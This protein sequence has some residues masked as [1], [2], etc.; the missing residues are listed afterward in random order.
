MWADVR[1]YS[2]HVQETGSPPGR[3]YHLQRRS[4]H[5]RY[6]VGAGKRRLTVKQGG[7]GGQFLFWIKLYYWEFQKRNVHRV[8]T[9][10]LDWL[11]IIVTFRSHFKKFKSWL[12]FLDSVWCFFRQYKKVLI[13]SKGWNQQ[14]WY[15][16]YII[17]SKPNSNFLR[18]IKS[19][20][21]G[22][23]KR[24]PGNNPCPAVSRGERMSISWAAWPMSGRHG[25]EEELE[26]EPEVWVW[27]WTFLHYV[28]TPLPRKGWYQH[29]VKGKL[30]P[31][32]SEEPR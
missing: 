25:R 3:T 11:I 32:L 12:H 26:V 17:L 7:V 6:S 30:G 16:N 28:L 18:S 14:N 31:E 9:V 15:V 23:W 20:N 29:F 8:S 19:Q 27:N 22:S 10:G 5:P 13:L 24:S 21:V 2:A 1:T 4:W